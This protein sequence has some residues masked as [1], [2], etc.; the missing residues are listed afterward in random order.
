MLL[1]HSE[2]YTRRNWYDRLTA[3]FVKF[4][5]H[6]VYAEQELACLSAEESELLDL[7]GADDR[8]TPF[9]GLDRLQGTAPPWSDSCD[10]DCLFFKIVG[11]VKPWKYWVLDPNKAAYTRRRAALEEEFTLSG[12]ALIEKYR[13][14]ASP[15]QADWPVTF[16]RAYEI[17]LLNNRAD[18]PAKR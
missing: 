10:R 17:Y 1:F 14:S 2:H 7:P 4:S 9:L 11:S 15:A 5:P 18:L 6:L 13:T 16:M 8:A 3:N 12:T